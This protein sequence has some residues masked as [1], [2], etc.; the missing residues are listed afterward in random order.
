MWMRNLYKKT[1]LHQIVKTLQTLKRSF[2][3]VPCLLPP[4]FEKKKMIFCLKIWWRK[5]RDKPKRAFQGQKRTFMHVPSLPL[6]YPPV[7]ARTYNLEP[8]PFTPPPPTFPLCRTIPPPRVEPSPS[9][10][11]PSTPPPPR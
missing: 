8:F 7:E 6:P 1:K 11:E 5:T 10:V 9:P 2:M 3:H 4:Y